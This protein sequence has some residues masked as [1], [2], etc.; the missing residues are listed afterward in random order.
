[1][2][3]LTGMDASFLYAETPR[4]HMAGGGIAIYDPSTAP[5]GRVT[6]KG[7]LDHIDKRLHEAAGV[8]PAAGPGAVRPRPPVLDRGPRL[9]PRV[10]RPP[11]RPAEAGRLAPAVHPGG[12]PDLA[13]ARPRPAAVGALR[14]RGARQRR[15]R[16]AGQLRARHQG[17]PRGHRRHVGHG[18]DDRHPR[19]QPD[20]RRRRRRRAVASGVGAE[21]GRAAVAGGRQQRHPPGARRSRDGAGRAP[22][23]PAARA[24]SA[25]GTITPP[26]TTIPRTR[27]SGPV[28]AHRVFD[29]DPA[30]ARRPA[31]DQADR[32]RG[33]DQRRRADDRRRR[34]ALV[35]ARPRTS[36]PP[37]R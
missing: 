8:P 23:R 19:R 25:S 9:R 17:P 16:A 13:P 6:F 11:H 3:Q 35:P 7:I 37:T 27:W 29:A 34:P 36:C 14:H 4:A 20:G 5:G 26:P 22:A 1:M 30:R 33:D 28:T 24:R 10:P 32:A 31:R 18:D 21:H 15:R 2:Q 12:P